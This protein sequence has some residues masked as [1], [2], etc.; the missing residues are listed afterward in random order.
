MIPML[1][2]ILKFCCVIFLNDL[3]IYFDRIVNTSLQERV[4][5]SLNGSMVWRNGH[6]SPNSPRSPR[7]ERIPEEQHPIKSSN[8]FHA[9]EIKPQPTAV[10]TLNA[11]IIRRNSQSP[12]SPSPPKIERTPVTPQR[13]IVSSTQKATPANKAIRKSIFPESPNEKRIIISRPKNSSTPVKVSYVSI[14]L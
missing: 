12:Q 9:N 8:I 10:T 4:D 6:S 1:D 5:T 11:T 13:K 2:A 3:S 14:I 7:T